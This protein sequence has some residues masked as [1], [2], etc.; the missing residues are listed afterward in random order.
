[1][2]G[3]YRKVVVRDGVL[4][5]A[6]LIGDL[7]R[8]GLLTQLYDRRTVLGQDEP[9]WLL[10]GDRPEGESTTAL[11]DDAEVCACAGVN[12]GAIRACADLETVV[13]KTRATTG[14]GSCKSTVCAL[15]EALAP[16]R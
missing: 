13:G 11:P 7:S 2:K 8:V 3:S 16:A 1:M 15:L 5:A 6:V 4:E 9:G 10:L 12:A 14:C